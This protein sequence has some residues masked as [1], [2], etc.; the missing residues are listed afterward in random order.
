MAKKR[1]SAGARARIAAA[2]AKAS[3]NKTKWDG[4]KPR[5]VKEKK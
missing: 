1:S 5:K 3:P 4:E 2:K